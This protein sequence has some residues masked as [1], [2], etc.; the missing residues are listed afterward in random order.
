MSGRPTG[1]RRRAHIDL[2]SILANAATAGSPTDLA[3]DLRADAYGHG[4]IPVARALSDAGVDGFLVSR[5]E[6]AAAL[7]DAGLTGARV[8]DQDA[9]GA[10]PGATVLGPE[11]FGLTAGAHPSATAMRLV[12]EII[13]VKR[14]AADS[15][16]SYGYTYRTPHETTL[17]LVALGFADGIPRVA[18]NKAPVRIGEYTGRVTGRIAMDQFVVDLDGRN[19]SPGDP[20]V[21]FGDAALG[22]PTVLDWADAIGIAAPVIT[23]RL[24]RR[25]ERVYSA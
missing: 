24:G 23:S 1:V 12:G 19:A 18:T 15:G 6:D 5:L 13:A 25:I 10:A 22:E 3:A 2:D 11:L 4:L 17:A 7:A 16:V 14:V 9:R 8:A 20:A 21:L